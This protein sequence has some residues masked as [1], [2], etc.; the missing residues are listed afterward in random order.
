MALQSSELGR[1]FF[2]RKIRSLGS[3]KADFLFMLIGT[4]YLV[5]L[6]ALVFTGLIK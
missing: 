3:I 1:N 6:S 4:K 5:H 2:L